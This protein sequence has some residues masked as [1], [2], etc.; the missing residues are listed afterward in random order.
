MRPPVELGEATAPSLLDG[1]LAL[2]L[3]TGAPL[4]LVGPLNGA[5]AAL[6]IAAA[7]IGDAATV[8]ATRAALGRT[9]PVEL[10][11]GHARAGV[12]VLDLREDGAVPRAIWALAWPLAL[13]GRPS[14]L[15]LSGP[16]HCEGQATFHD[17]RLGWVP[18]A[19]RFGLKVS[20]ELPLAGFDGENGEVIASFDPAP[21]L[22]PLQLVHR[23]ILRQVSVV[24]ATAQGRDDDPLRAAQAAARKLRAHG[25]IAEPERVPL[26][27]PQGSRGGRWALT[28]VAE[29]E[30]SIFTA[31]ALG[32][33]RERPAPLGP[34]PTPP[35]EEAGERVAERLG[36]FLAAGGALEGRMAERLLVPA[37]LCAAG[38]G[39]RAGTAPTCHF[40]T[41]NV[42]EGLVSL[43]TL[44]R[45][46]LPVKAVVD[47]AVGEEGVVVVAPAT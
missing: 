27:H 2:A 41:S 12:H 4:R 1:A 39:A 38:L 9:G 42:T 6:V 21:A 45:R 3:A 7:R 37:I 18:L 33:R 15:R 32:A 35:P 40:T 10:T 14:E 30:N 22:T 5:D 36:R 20:L 26:P 11:L 23:G 28:A 17:L 19:A 47:G 24:A 31:S 8:D 25:V 43:A 16:N 29:F 34:Q 46:M 44:A 13:L